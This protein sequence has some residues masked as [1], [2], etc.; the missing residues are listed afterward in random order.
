MGPPP[1][2]G[3]PPTPNAPPLPGPQRGG[4]FPQT[5][6]NPA[7]TIGL[8]FI[9]PKGKLKAIHWDKVDAP[10]VTVWASHIPTHQAKE[11]KYMELSRKGVLDEV[12]KL[13]MAKEIKKIGAA[14][15][16]KS[17][18]KQIIGSDL[19]QKFL[20]SLSKFSTQSADEVVQMILHC[21]RDIL[22]NHVVMEFLQREDLCIVPDNTAKLMAPY[23]KDWTG[24]DAERTQR[25]Q[26]PSELTRED[27]I[28]LATAYELHHYWKSRMRALSL[29]RTFE[30]EYDEISGHLKE[31][32]TVSES[33]RDSV[34]LM[35]ILGLILDIGNYMNDS[36]KQAT[37]FKLSSLARLGM[38]K[39]EK[40]ESTFAD[41]VER[42]VRKQYPQWEG[43]V[44]DI[45][46]VLTVQKLNVEQL[47]LDAKK[48]IDNIRNVQMS[49]DSGNLSDSKKFHP[50]DRVNQVVQRSM[51]EARRKAEQMQLYLDEMN[52]TYDDIMTF[53][54]EDST[55]DNA[56]R[57][58]F[59]KLAKFVTEWKR[60][61]EKNINMEETHK[62]NEA[63]MA[64]KR[65]NAKAINPAAANSGAATPDGSLSPSSTGA[66]DSLLEKLRAAAP[67]ARDT[68]DRRRRARLKDRHQIRIASGQSIPDLGEVSNSGTENEQPEKILLSPKAAING[69][70][71]S[72][73]MEPI[74][75]GEDVAERAA[76]MLQ[77]LRANV[78]GDPDSGRP[79]SRDGSLRVRRRRES[80]NDERQTRR[81]RRRVR[82]SSSTT[83]DEAETLSPRQETP[84]PEIQEPE[85]DDGGDEAEEMDVPKTIVVPPSPEGTAMKPVL[86]DD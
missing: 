66:M 78:D 86:L 25:E 59:D 76:N 3:A 29:T 52:R 79:G 51:K 58:F 55:D 53:Y 68:R 23:S 5:Q 80:A 12:E 6:Y 44:D 41:L 13:F 24:P 67:Q 22:D 11:E 60:S 69:D 8:P 82:E 37:G 36:N 64:R 62:R 18:K 63:S 38:V 49:L 10:Q 84:L 42:I 75:E 73:K 72:E 50:Q 43:F 14:K 70:A 32:V 46:G 40:N 2:P 35:N 1:T 83:G 17:D 54:G 4:Y 16:G 33:L 65:A 15:G 39:D 47:R 85:G 28:Y 19:R 21:D 31:I 48:Y 71:P 77:G 57:E 74:S 7:P 34:A 61:K 26:D 20:I 27:Q 81:S 30:G 45:G 9:R 56:R